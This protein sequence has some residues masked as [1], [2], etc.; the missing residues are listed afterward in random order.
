[1]CLGGGGSSD[2]TSSGSASANVTFTPTITIGANTGEPVQDTTNTFA[3][4]LL[5]TPPARIA[6]PPQVA[7]KPAT[8]NS[9]KVLAVLAV[10]LVARK[11]LHG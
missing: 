2:S 4:K 6:L 3:A 10:A 8:N 9:T 5:A 7:E 11:V 1:M